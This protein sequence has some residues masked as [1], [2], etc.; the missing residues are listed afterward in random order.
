MVTWMKVRTRINFANFTFFFCR[1]ALHRG[2]YARTMEILQH[3][4]V[5]KVNYHLEVCNASPFEFFMNYTNLPTL[6][7]KVYEGN[8]KIKSAKEISLS[9]D[10]SKNLEPLVIYTTC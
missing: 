10:R 3:A 8:S 1:I 5:L 4:N 9:K 2:I 7:S 6:L